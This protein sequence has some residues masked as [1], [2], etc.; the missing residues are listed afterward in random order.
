MF[1]EEIKVG[2]LKTNCYVIADSDMKESAVIDPGEDFEEI[3]K[4]LDANKLIPKYVL[5]T[6]GHYDHITEAQSVADSYGAD[7]ICHED[8]VEFLNNSLLSGAAYNESAATAKATQVVRENDKIHLGNLDINVLHV[9]G[10]A[11]GSVCYYI[12]E[13]NVLFSGDTLFKDTI[14]ITDIFPYGDHKM[15]VKNIKEK[16]LTLPGKTVVYAGHGAQTTIASEIKNNY[17]LK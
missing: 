15:L 3:A 14:G 1:I 10:H 7:I 8:A 6:H 11:P 9:P 5:I 4:V 12:E 13:E 17:Y 16:L 2:A